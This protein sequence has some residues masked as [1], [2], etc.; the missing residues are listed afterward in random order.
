VSSSL[1]VSSLRCRVLLIDDDPAWQHLI[2]A[3]LAAHGIEVVCAPA[4]LASLAKL[5]AEDVQ[6]VLLD[7]NPR[8]GTGVGWCQR[9]RRWVGDRAI[10]VLALSRHDDESLIQSAFTAGAA[11]FFVKSLQWAWLAERTVQLVEAAGLRRTLA[12]RQRRLQRAEDLA[13]SAHQAAS[14]AQSLAEHDV[15][16]GLLNRNG[17][18]KAAQA[19]LDAVERSGGSAGPPVLLLLN[20]DRFKRLNES[21]G[22]KAAD[23]V[24]QEVACRLQ[25]AFKS[26]SSLVIGRLASDEFGVFFATL[27]RVQAAEGAAQIILNELQRPMTCAGM[28]CVV[29][30]SIGIAMGASGVA[31]DGL[32]AQASQ[33]MTAVKR[34][35]GQGYKRFAVLESPLE[36]SGFDL[37][38]ALHQAIERAELVLH[39]QPIVNQRGSRLAGVEALMRWQ[40]QGRLVSPADFI[41]IAEASGLI[42]TMGEWAIHEALR[43]VRSWRDN[44][45]LI[46]TVAVNIHPGHLE[47]PSLTAAVARALEKYRLES[48]ALELELTETGV[49]RDVGKAVASL[50]ALKQIGVRLA[51]DDFGTGYSSLA[52]LTQLPINTLKIDRSFV[53]QLNGSGQTRAVVRSITALA[54]ALGLSTI[55]E[56]VETPEQL[57]SVR[58]LGCQE[59]Q[60][61]VYAQPMPATDLPLWVQRFQGAVRVPQWVGPGPALA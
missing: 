4:E 57:D 19:E 7:L 43:Q 12:M 20:L 35:G 46:N 36:P 38:T 15:L 22:A 39:Y 8:H 18:M 54:Q 10:P 3:G 6:A 53:H 44:G 23:A 16:T 47:R 26:C 13:V 40:H 29:R 30:A 42:Y 14:R 2:A 61:F 52:Y 41:P 27:R 55:A 17:F 11:D 58:S 51:L 59:V 48:S 50:Q 32:W 60:G 33:A 24:L 49:M 1:S 37:E 31:L 21:L 28:T 56:G 34:A 25:R 9:V 5:D 45:V